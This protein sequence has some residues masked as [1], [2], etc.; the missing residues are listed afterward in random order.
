MSVCRFSPAQPLGSYH[1]G[2]D[3]QWLSRPPGHER[4]SRSR[5][6]IVLMA[7][8]MCGLVLLSSVGV[9]RVTRHT[10]RLEH[11]IEAADDP[12]RVSEMHELVLGIAH[13]IR[14]PLNAIRLNLHTVGQVFRDEAAL[15][16]EEI[17]HDARRDGERDCAAGD[18][19]ARDA[20][21]CA[22]RGPERRADRR[23]ARKSSGRWALAG[24]FGA[25]AACEVRLDMREVRLALS[26]W[27]PTRLRQVLLNLLN[28]GDGG[29]GRRRARSRSAV[30]DARGAGGDCRRGRR[31]GHR[32]GGPRAGVCAVFF[33]ESQRHGT[34]V[35]PWP[36]NSSRRPAA[37]SPAR[38]GPLRGVACFRILLP[39]T[40]R[41]DNDRFHERKRPQSM[42]QMNRNRGFWWSKIRNRS[43]TRLERVLR[44]AQY[45]VVTAASAEEALDWRDQAIDLVI[46]DLRMGR[47]SGI[48]LLMEWRE[49]R[50]ETPFIL[51]TAF[52]DVDSAVRA[53]KLGAVRLSDQAGRSRAA[54]GDR[55]RVL[56]QPGRDPNGR[57]RRRIGRPSAVRRRMGF[58]PLIGASPVDA[59]RLRPDSPRGRRPTAS[60]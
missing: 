25:A 8:G 45:D 47:R 19:D 14:N 46:S 2:L 31:A 7:A 13:E 54:A 57:P 40:V 59:G 37:R 41:R 32:G 3:S 28:N 26:R 49:V 10:A 36:A 27:T 42:R 52:G 58:G 23:D 60:C 24:Q 6:W 33:D 11:E 35:W 15:G 44:V 50:P 20:G 22:R 56:S 5:F 9:V 21:L 30:Q 53:M 51:A 4:T 17:A 1:T 18:A 38:S 55:A 43:G 39:A 34:G 29:G 12:R 16:D 48:D